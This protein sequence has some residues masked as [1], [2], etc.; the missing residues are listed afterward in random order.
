MVLNLSEDLLIPAPQEEVWKLLRDTPRFTAL[1]PGVESVTPLN[2]EGAEA[3]AARVTEKVGPFKITL[4][5]E[6]RLA[7][8]QEPSL[9]KAGVKG[10]DSMG[11]NRVTGTLQASLAPADTGTQMH[12]EAAIEILGKMATLGAV[13]IRRRT[14]ESFTLFAKNIQAQSSKENS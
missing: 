7:E 6:V 3:Y 12:F 2:E 1:L 14:T 11:M 9:L 5:V 8:T 4:N 10:G 13:P